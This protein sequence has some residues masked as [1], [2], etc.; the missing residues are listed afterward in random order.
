MHYKK[1][2][3]RCSCEC[4]RGEPCPIPDGKCI[5]GGVKY[6]RKTPYIHGRRPK[7][8]EGSGYQM[9]SATTLNHKKGR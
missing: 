6:Q 5:G 8:T 4:D 1:H 3:K 7:M 2:K 9:P